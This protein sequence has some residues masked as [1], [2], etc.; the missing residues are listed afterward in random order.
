[1]QRVAR[2]IADPLIRIAYIPVVGKSVALM[3]GFVG[4]LWANAFFAAVALLMM[5][6]VVDWTLGSYRA[7]LRDPDHPEAY[8]PIRA[9]MGWV[10]KGSGMAIALLLFG[11]ENWA[12][13]LGN[14]TG[15][16][17]A[18]GFVLALFVA[19]LKSI[20]RLRLSTGG[21]QIAVF[22]RAMEAWDA[23][24]EKLVGPKE[25]DVTDN[26]DPDA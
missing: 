15:S 16:W 18:T 11:V 21:P 1:M 20:N 3:A 2:G 22:D 17:I 25:K 10:S 13:R 19:E 9:R 5:A 8:D 12:T 24:A 23:L 6:H 7:K 4:V 14:P 26:R